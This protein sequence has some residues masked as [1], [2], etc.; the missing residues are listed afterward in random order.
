MT[1]AT[2]QDPN[3]ALFASLLANKATNPGGY[4]GTVKYASGNGPIDPNGNYWVGVNGDLMS[5]T[6]SQP[7]QKTGIGKFMD[8]GGG[9]SPGSGGLQGPRNSVADLSYSPQQNDPVNAAL[10]NQGVTQDQL[11]NYYRANPTQDSKAL[12]ADVAI[13]NPD[14]LADKVLQKIALGSSVAA[15]TAGAGAMLG[16]GAAA[17]AGGGAAAGGTGGG[18]A[19]AGLSPLA[20]GALSGGI[21]GAAGNLLTNG[22][23]S[24]LLTSIGTGALGGALGSG[25]SSLSGGLS[26]ATG[27]NPTL[28]TGLVRGAIGAGTGALGGALSGTGA[29]HGALIGGVSGATSGLVG[30]ATGVPVLGGVAGSLAGAAANRI[31]PPTSPALPG[32]VGGAGTGTIGTPPPAASMPTMPGAS[33]ATST[34]SMGMPAPGAAPS[35]IG[36]YSGYGYAPRTQTDPNINYAT[37]GQG[38][39]AQFYKTT[40]T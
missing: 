28:A 14:S 24:G 35:N 23:K 18:L 12:Q 2:N 4:T 8:S 26:G 36:S 3:A 34:T 30:G 37:Y 40:G 17:G 33:Q 20:A 19:G 15:I 13:T 31:S 5:K 39:E 25:A 32:R 27:L 16:A 11:A 7:Q 38:P 9:D 10:Y 1:T 21:G 22:G 6:V 29:G